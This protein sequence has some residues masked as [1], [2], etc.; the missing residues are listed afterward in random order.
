MFNFDESKYISEFE[1]FTKA[2]KDKE[3]EEENRS[4]DE[5]EKNE[6]VLQVTKT[7]KQANSILTS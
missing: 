2:S 7:N 5:R 6:T 3:E 1:F 4:K